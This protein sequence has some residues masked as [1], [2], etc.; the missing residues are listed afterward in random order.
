[1]ITRGDGSLNH[2]GSM[3]GNQAADKVGNDWRGN[4]NGGRWVVREMLYDGLPAQV[5][6]G[7]PLIL[8][9]MRLLR[10]RAGTS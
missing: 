7:A 9:G 6:Q 10:L 3:R 1:M 4:V 8:S 2:A 5:G